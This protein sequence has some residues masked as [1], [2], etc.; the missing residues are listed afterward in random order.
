L[1][2]LLLYRDSARYSIIISKTMIDTDARI[3]F[4]PLYKS[5]QKPVLVKSEKINLAARPEL[6]EGDGRSNTASRAI[7]K[8]LSDK[9][10]KIK[11]K[12]E[13]KKDTKKIKKDM[14]T[15]KQAAKPAVKK[16]VEPVVQKVCEQASQS[17]VVP[18]VE[19]NPVENTLFVGQQEMDA[20]SQYQEI[21]AQMKEHWAPPIGMAPD[22]ECV[23]MLTIDKMGVVTQMKVEKSSGVLLFDTAARKAVK[24]MV[25]PAWAYDKELSLT[26]KV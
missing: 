10:N 22:L 3:V 4:M 13:K 24:K 18:T 21:Q 9:K 25:A 8:E 26:F 7:F 15:S 12:P 20:L 1:S 11:K 17:A 23:I 14:Q 19:Q 2:I 5:L 6:V 16:T